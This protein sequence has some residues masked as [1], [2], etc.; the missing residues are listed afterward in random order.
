FALDL[1]G[2]MTSVNRAVE[3]VTGYTQTELMGMNMS[4]FLT[5]ESTE[6]ARRMTERKLA[7]EERTNYE[8]DVPAK[9]GRIL[10]LE[11]SSR[12]IVNQGKP[13]GV[14]GVA[15]DITT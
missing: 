3:S 6:S 11:I 15:R 12:L 4:D 2:N 10:R 7:G 1:E 5:P 8:V 13:V 9:D 14:Q